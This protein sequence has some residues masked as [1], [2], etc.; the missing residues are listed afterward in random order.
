[1]KQRSETRGTNTK[2]TS[3]RYDVT[4]QS[5]KYQIKWNL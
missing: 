3:A 2:G 1:M 5:N 4:K